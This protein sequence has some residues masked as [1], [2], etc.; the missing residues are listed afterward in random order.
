MD[1]IIF[2][3][4]RM[5]STRLPGKILKKISGKTILE[6][7]LERL[8]NIM[9]VQQVLVTGP[10]E[11]NQE[12]IDESNRLDLDFFCG[13]E[14]NLLDRYY[15][16]CCVFNAENII[17][18]TGD[19]PLVDSE[20]IIDGMNTFSQKKCDVLSS[21]N[22]LFPLG[23]NFDIMKTDTIKESWN[24]ARGEFSSTETFEKT[25]ISPVKYIVDANKFK[26]QNYSVGNIDPRLRLTVDYEEDFILVKNIYENLYHKNNQFTL[27][28]IKNFLEENP[29]I[30]KI[31]HKWCKN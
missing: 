13:S 21:E 20:L 5:N 15:Q 16:A 24:V 19:N 23:M 28:D 18:L 4:A 14:E 1:N 17:R 22:D 31:N 30:K 29:D 25:F 3:Q 8:E 26:I 10:S 12:L 27:D 11:K 6:I 2:I 7:I 9:D